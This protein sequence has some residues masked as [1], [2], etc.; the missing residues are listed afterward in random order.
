[1]SILLVEVLE[2]DV[3]GD[4]L[5]SDWVKVGHLEDGHAAIV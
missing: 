5:A 4:L 3:E 2:V 1:M